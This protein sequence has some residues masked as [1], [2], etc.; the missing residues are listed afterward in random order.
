MLACTTRRVRDAGEGLRFPRFTFRMKVFLGATQTVPVDAS[1]LPVS[2]GTDSENG[3][4]Q[5]SAR[6]RVVRMVAEPLKLL[7]W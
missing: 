4:R 1:L 2:E 6:G 3:I 7:S 5:E